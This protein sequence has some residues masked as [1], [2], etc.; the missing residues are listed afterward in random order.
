[1]TF[2]VS[3]NVVMVRLFTLYGL[4]VAAAVS[5]AAAAEPPSTAMQAAFDGTI[6][7]TYPD[8]RQAKLWLDKDG[9]YTAEG[10]RK[11]RSSGHWKVKGDKVCLSQSRPLP[12]PFAFCTP[13]PAAREW[14][15]KALTGERIK[16]KLVP[17]GRPN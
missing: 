10:R 8:G 17:G 4:A 5:T 11:D 12:S 2:G 3:G 16:V 1:M 14:T 9:A 7:S 13:K 6:V 15:A